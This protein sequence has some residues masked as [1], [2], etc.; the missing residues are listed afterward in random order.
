MTSVLTFIA[1]ERQ[2]A[3]SADFRRYYGTELRDAVNSWAGEDLSS[4]IHSLPPDSA[5]VREE[6]GDLWDY[7]HMAANIAM[8]VDLVSYQVHTDYAKS[9]YD[10]E[11]PANK[12]APKVKPPEHPIIPPV[13]FR[14]PSVAEKHVEQYAEAL[15][16]A[17]EKSQDSAQESGKQWV[18]SA[19]FDAVLDLI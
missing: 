9:I 11:D 7:N 6:L 19:E 3:L 13:A 4:A 12:N 18:S 15:I 5:T 8:L 16:N 17:G 10:P 1:G 14:P 2:N